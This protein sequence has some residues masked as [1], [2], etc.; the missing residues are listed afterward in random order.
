MTGKS[1]VF[2]APL[3]PANGKKASRPLAFSDEG[4][5]AA[6]RAYIRSTEKLSNGELAAIFENAKEF[7]KV[8]GPSGS[9]SSQ[10]E[11]N[12]DDERAFLVNGDESDDSDVG[13]SQE[14]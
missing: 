7:A 13:H 12:L 6:T 8:T 1:I 10:G 3:N 9:K 11:T 4:W 5:G 14:G 2:N